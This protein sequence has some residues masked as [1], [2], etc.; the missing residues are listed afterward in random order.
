MTVDSDTLNFADI[1]DMV[2]VAAQ[3]LKISSP[4]NLLFGGDLAIIFLPAALF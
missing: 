2:I 1:S 3:S 4:G